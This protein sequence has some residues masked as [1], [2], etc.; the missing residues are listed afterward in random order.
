[1]LTDDELL[2]LL[3]GGE[4]DRVEFTTDGE[5]AGADDKIRRNVCAFANDLPGH[6]KPGAMFIGVN[7]DGSCANIPRTKILTEKLSELRLNAGI[8][9]FPV[10]AVD[11]KTLNDCRMV[12]VIVEPSRSGP[13]SY[14]GDIWVRSGPTCRKATQEEEDA[15]VERRSGMRKDT[16]DCVA[17]YPRAGVK[18]LNIGL[19]HEYLSMAV[20][21]DSLAENNRTD[22]A[23]MRAMGFMTPDNAVTWGAILCFGKN[24]QKWLRG[25]YIQFLRCPGT[26]IVS[27]AEAID[28]KQIDGTIS[29]QIQVIE[30]LMK[31][32]I[33]TPAIIGGERR[34]D[35][36][37]YPY[38]ALQQAIRNAVLHRS[39]EGT[40]APIQCY[41]FNDRVEI[42]S[43][44][45]PYGRVTVDNFASQE[46]M[47][48]YRN[49][50]LA[51]VMGKTQLIEKYGYGIGAIRR[52]MKRNG[53]SPPEFRVGETN[54]TVVLRKLDLD[55]LA[56][57]AAELVCC[58]GLFRLKRDWDS[59]PPEQVIVQISGV[60]KFGDNPGFPKW[61]GR[62]SQFH[63]RGE[64]ISAKA[65]ALEV[66][67]N[68]TMR[69]LIGEPV[70]SSASPESRDKT[71]GPKLTS[72]VKM[73]RIMYILRE[74]FGAEESEMRT[75]LERSLFDEY[76]I[77]GE[78][79][80][81]KKDDADFRHLLETRPSLAEIEANVNR[82]MADKR[83]QALLVSGS[84]A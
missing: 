67:A 70:I 7:D 45:G 41:W 16:Y 34:V 26:E 36:P 56:A 21:P 37:A 46:G 75:V 40:N 4:S 80:A 23:R 20:S 50:K 58:Q 15:L 12:T 62:A 38:V 64:N 44:G 68:Y 42:S 5:S 57:K 25:A 78:K 77:P 66:T 59:K 35:F 14:N 3:R 17:V 60:S 11:E 65:V 83:M 2:E 29:R 69:K 18:E 22:D 74:L 19:F 33:Q 43:P 52:S 47:T 30:S 24:P 82:E 31:V 79:Q 39:Y 55:A 71:S 61:Q 48:D 84:L 81:R 9:P 1:M 73:A 8:H 63:A 6:G 10:V 53:N 27:A 76:P 51:E 32:H 49:P 13:T 54:V 28:H 72:L